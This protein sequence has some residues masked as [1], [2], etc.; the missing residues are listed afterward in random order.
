MSLSTGQMTGSSPTPPGLP[1]EEPPGFQDHGKIPHYMRGDDELNQTRVL[2]L[3][4]K[5]EEDKTKNPEKNERKMIPRLPEP[6]IIETS[7]ELAVGKKEAKTIKASREGR[8]YLLCTNSRTITEKLTKMTELIDKTEFEI[9]VHPTLNTV[10]GTVYEPDSINTDMN[11]FIGKLKSQ[12]VQS[13]RRIKKRINGDLQ[14]TPLLVITFNGSVLPKYVYFCMLRIAVRP[15]YPLPLLCFKCGAYGHPQKFCP[16][17]NSICM[18]CSQ[19]SHLADGERCENP[20]HCFHCKNGHPT[21]S[22]DC[23]KYKEE[24]QIVHIKVNQC[25]SFIEARRIYNE[26]NKKESIQNQLKQE[27]TAKD[28]LIANL[29]KQVD[30]LA[31]QVAQLKSA[32]KQR[33]QSRPSTPKTPLTQPNSVAKTGSSPSQKTTASQQN[34]TRLS[35]KDQVEF[36]QQ[37]PKLD[38]EV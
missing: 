19:A 4:R 7:V 28:I 29:Q 20:P 11:V 3:Q 8:R 6:F 30:L 1:P 21:T 32:L 27:L 22:R 5:M 16:Q 15:Y 35:R 14:N 23:P 31:K 13:I 12:G 26:E 37:P 38:K 18:R 10:Q 25:I 2:V 33:S 24:N 36:A 34:N 9:F 17:Q